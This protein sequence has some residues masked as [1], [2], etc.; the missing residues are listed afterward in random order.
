MP[1][2]I[3]TRSGQ[4]GEVALFAGLDGRPVEWP[5]E[6]AAQRQVELLKQTAGY[7]PREP[8]NFEYVVVPAYSAPLLD[9]PPAA[10]DRGGLASHARAVLNDLADRVADCPCQNEDHPQPTVRPPFATRREGLAAMADF[11]NES[12]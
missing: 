11:L 2:N 5:D 7:G 6:A 3:G 12:T 4:T 1:F 9:I 10:P 8:R